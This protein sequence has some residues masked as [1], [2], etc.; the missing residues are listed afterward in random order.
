MSNS[1]WLRHDDEDVATDVLLD[2]AGEAFAA[3]GVGKA[4]MVDV[5]RSAGCSRAT[6]YRYFPNRTA[7]H[8]A[9]VQRAWLR[10]AASA[11][12]SRAPSQPLTADEITDRVTLGVLAVRSDPLLA[13]WFEP[14]NMSIPLA[15]S[16]DS[17]VLRAMAAAFIGEV[18]GSEVNDA[19][20]ERRGAWMLR[21][22]VSLLVMPGADVAAERE[23]VA[24]YVVPVLFP[25]HASPRITP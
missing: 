16:Q 4:S 18:V 21:I 24:S 12:E 19:E 3:I 2:A 5:A 14:E 7:L 9:F 17:D 25:T 22:I 15:L 10:I 20:A 23:L 8:Q 13:V 1:V 11:A 6:L